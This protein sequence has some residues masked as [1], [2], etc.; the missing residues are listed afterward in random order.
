MRSRAQESDLEHGEEYKTLLI[1]AIHRCATRYAEVADSIVLVLLD[2][3][4]GEG[5]Y[6]VMQC[7]KSIIEQYPT[8]RP[9][10][11]RK[12]IDNLDEITSAE[13]LRVALWV[14]GEYSE[15]VDS[16]VSTLHI[17]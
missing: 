5:G 3:L 1:Q 11:V 13:A 14:L 8:F 7:V 12:V 2:F 4:A 9:S 6:N 15:A 17:Q 10:V 16:A